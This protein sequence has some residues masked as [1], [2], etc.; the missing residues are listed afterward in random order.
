MSENFNANAWFEGKVKELSRRT[1]RAFREAVKDGEE[2]TK[3]NIETRGTTKSGKRGR[4]ESGAMRDSVDSK[5]TKENQEEIEGWF[6]YKDGPYWTA[7]QEP[8]FVH[9]GSG[10]FVEGTYA[11]TDAGAEII[12][13]LKEDIDKIVKDS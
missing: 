4:I 3:D 2:L 5:I 6:G 12:Q 13:N 10:Q 11:L 1:R 7:F 8:G 9:Y